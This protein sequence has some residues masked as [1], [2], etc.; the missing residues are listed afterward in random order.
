MS[1]VLLAFNLLGKCNKTIVSN[2][3]RNIH[4]CKS[5]LFKEKN[6]RWFN[7]SFNQNVRYFSSK[8]KTT[9]KIS[10][11]LRSSF[12][13]GTATATTGFIYNSKHFSFEWNKIFDKDLLK[14]LLFEFLSSFLKT[15]ECEGKKN[16]T[17]D[18]EKTA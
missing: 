10:F 3:I 11:L 6:I 15:A 18:Y 5:N 2:Q 13:V 4:Y 17:T 1:N 8:L 16:R 12:L 14:D 9:K 7:T